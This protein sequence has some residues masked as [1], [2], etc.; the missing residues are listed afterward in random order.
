M[1]NPAKSCFPDLN[2][3]NHLQDLLGVEHEQNDNDFSGETRNMIFNQFLQALGVDQC[4]HP[5]VGLMMMRYDKKC[6]IQS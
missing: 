2:F 4:S 3:C 6:F 1:S 5:T